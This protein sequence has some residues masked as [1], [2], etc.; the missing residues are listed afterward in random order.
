MQRL[1]AKYFPGLP[2]MEMIRRQWIKIDTWSEYEH[3]TKWQ[4]H[5]RE[6]LLKHVVDELVRFTQ[7]TNIEELKV[8]LGW[9]GALLDFD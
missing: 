5:E 9:E 2:V 7:V 1:F 4:Q 8:K 6:E 3:K